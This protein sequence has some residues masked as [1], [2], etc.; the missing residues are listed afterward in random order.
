MTMCAGG[1]VFDRGLLTVV[2]SPVFCLTLTFIYSVSVCGVNYELVNYVVNYVTHTAYVYIPS[3]QSMST[4]NVI[5]Q[6]PVAFL[7]PLIRGPIT[8]KK[9]H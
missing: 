1:L 8:H 4:C 2:A 7:L 3:H 6:A 5:Q 9:D